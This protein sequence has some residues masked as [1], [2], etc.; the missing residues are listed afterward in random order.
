MEETME[1]EAVVTGKTV[2]TTTLIKVMEVKT[3][4]FNLK[5]SG[6]IAT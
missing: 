3:T 2:T 4:M 1:E 6:R 5:A